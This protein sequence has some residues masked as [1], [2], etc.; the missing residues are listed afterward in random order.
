MPLDQQKLQTLYQCNRT[1]TTFRRHAWWLLFY[2]HRFRDEFQHVSVSSPA[3]VTTEIKHLFISSH[4]MTQLS[5]MKQ[6]Q[7][8]FELEAASVVVLCPETTTLQ[9][10][11]VP[12]TKPF[13]AFTIFSD[14]VR[15]K[16]LWSAF[17]LNDKV[18]IVCKPLLSCFL[19][20]SFG[21]KCFNTKSI[22]RRVQCYW[23]FDR[24]R[25]VNKPDACFWL[26]SFY[27]LWSF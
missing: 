21:P 20:F 26:L 6:R 9:M 18:F 14:H 22:K 15:C 11:L 13:I 1:T 4:F 24:R 19:K 23:G 10:K 16:N 17:I 27:L 2:L 25:P 7:N 8:I 12:E 5:N 3:S